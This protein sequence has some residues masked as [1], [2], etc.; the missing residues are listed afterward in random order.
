MKNS[1]AAHTATLTAGINETLVSTQTNRNLLGDLSSGQHQLSEHM[2]GILVNSMTNQSDA[3][4]R[5]A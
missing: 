2:G 1:L 5:Q 3:M 4:L